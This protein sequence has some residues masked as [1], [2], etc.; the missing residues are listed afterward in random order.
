MIKKCIDQIAFSIKF[1]FFCILNFRDAFL[2]ILL[3]GV[4]RCGLAERGG[5]HCDRRGP[6]ITATVG[7][8]CP[9]KWAFA[10]RHMK[11]SK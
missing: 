1:F 6:P 4:R 8:I 5:V 9:E 2:M 11:T 3:P 7:V 10:P